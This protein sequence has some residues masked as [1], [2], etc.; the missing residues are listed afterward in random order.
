MSMAATPVRRRPCLGPR[1]RRVAAM[2]RA[3]ES[4]MPESHD[5]RQDELPT[6]DSLEK[7]FWRVI[8]KLAAE[9]FVA[10]PNDARNLIV[11]FQSE[12]WDGL[13]KRFQS[14]LGK[15]PAYAAGAFYRFARRRIIRLQLWERRLAD[16]ARAKQ[17]NEPTP[18][19][20]LEHREQLEEISRAIENLPTDERRLLTDYLGGPSATERQLAKEYGISRY[21]VREHLINAVGRIAVEL[22][23][24]AT[25]SR[26]DALIAQALWSE[27]RTLRDVAAE[28]E[29]PVDDV[30]ASRDRSILSLFG[31][32]RQIHS[33]EK[34]RP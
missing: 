34:G 5:P 3:T 22:G 26:H 13:A 18:L 4:D 32:L 24:L 21:A 8:G 11:D 17:K 9:G 2:A 1:F 10:R 14:S 31:A 33:R 12:A 29:V 20:C 30:R 27:G 19:E 15:F 7:L 28:L 23:K 25:V 6:F 16:I